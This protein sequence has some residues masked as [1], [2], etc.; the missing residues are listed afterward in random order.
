MREIKQ[1]VQDNVRYGSDYY[2]QEVIPDRQRVKDAN[3][4]Y[5]AEY[6]ICLIEEYE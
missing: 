3:D 6:R 5:T 1:H 4:Q 2:I